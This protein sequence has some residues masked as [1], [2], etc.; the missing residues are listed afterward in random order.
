[1]NKDKKQK[2]VKAL[3]VAASVLEGTA[4][5]SWVSAASPIKVQEV[6]G[7]L[8][9]ASVTL[10]Q[11]GSKA[12]HR[13]GV[14]RSG[15][16]VVKMSGMPGVSVQH[17]DDDIDELRLAAASLLNSG[18][19]IKS[20]TTQ[21]VLSNGDKV[22]SRDVIGGAFLVIQGPEKAAKAAPKRRKKRLTTDKAKEVL[23]IIRRAS[24]SRMPFRIGP[25]KVGQEV[26]VDGQDYLVYDM[27]FVGDEEVFVLVSPN[28]AHIIQNVTKQ[29]IK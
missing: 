7:A 3:L 1:M 24:S 21:R 15:I 5:D 17:T 27:D 10:A 18:F 4:R 22:T 8:R 14:V 29:E 28:G 2:V 26:T 20:P 25:F 11:H 13:R 9:K 6:M 19:T 16:A 12:R 23:G